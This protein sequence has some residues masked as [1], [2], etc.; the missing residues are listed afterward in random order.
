MWG[1]A[2]TAILYPSAN[3]ERTM[4]MAKRHTKLDDGFH[5]HLVEGAQFEGSMGI[6]IMLDLKNTCVPRDIVPF[7]KIG[8]ISMAEQAGVYVH[9][10]MHDNRFARILYDTDACLA[11]AEGCA[12]LIPPDFTILEGQSPCLQ[13]TNVHFNRA[14]GFYA[15]VHGTSVIPNV[16]WGEPATYSFC[17]LGIPEGGIVC[18][19]THGCMKSN[20][21][22]DSFRNGLAEM[23]HRLCPEDVLVHGKMPADVFDDFKSRTCFHRYPS[24]FERTHERKEV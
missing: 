19:S 18:V 5:A 21:D 13:A 15:Q 10:Y 24:W 20:R 8:K 22:K 17:F 6:P 2:T 4:H 14:V 7:E 3:V 11:K 1:F 12:G 9:F 23:I 16:R